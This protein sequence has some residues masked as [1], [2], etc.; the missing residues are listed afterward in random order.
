MGNCVT[1]C[2]FS[3]T[4]TFEEVRLYIVLVYAYA[5]QYLRV[6]VDVVRQSLPLVGDVERVPEP[7]PVSP[8]L[9]H[10]VMVVA[11]EVRVEDVAGIVAG[12]ARL[13]T[14]PVEYDIERTPAYAVDL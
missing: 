12:R 9:I 1:C 7:R 10:P 8:V 2:F 11:E 5:E 6:S 4:L 14:Q 13:L 3:G